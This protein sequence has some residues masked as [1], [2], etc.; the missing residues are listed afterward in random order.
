MFNFLF[1]LIFFCYAVGLRLKYRI[2]DRK[3]LRENNKEIAH[4]HSI[5]APSPLPPHSLVQVGLKI[6]FAEPLSPFL[7]QFQLILSGL[8]LLCVHT[9]S[10]I[11]K[12]VRVHNKSVPVDIGQK[13]ESSLCGPIIAVH[14]CAWQNA[15]LNDEQKSCCIPSV[16]HLEIASCGTIRTRDSTKHP[17]AMSSLPSPVVLKRY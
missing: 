6:F 16:H 15:S 5:A 1:F 11:H 17:R 3:L 14:F 13:L 12:I 10:W 7:P 9:C 2:I 8:H 4:N